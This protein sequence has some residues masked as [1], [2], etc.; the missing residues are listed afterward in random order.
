[1]NMTHPGLPIAWITTVVLVMLIITV[2]SLAKPAPG[3]QSGRTFNLSQIPLVGPLVNWL[4]TS[5]QLLL[6]LKLLMVLIFLTVIVAGLFG[7]P[8]PERNF[9]TLITWNFWWAGLVF[10]IFFFGTAWCAV[11]PWDALA[12]WLVRRR[13]SKRAEPNNSLNWSLPRYL[14]NLWPALIL[15]VGLTW[16]E[17]GVGITTS[18]QGTALVAL[19]MVVMA[20]VSLALFK[21]KAFCRHICPVGRTVGAYSQLAVVEL[22]PADITICAGCTT[23]DCYH[24]NQLVE[25]CP[26]FLMMGKLKQNSYCT[27]CGN[28][29]QSCPDDNVSWRLRAPSSEAAQGARPHW[30]EAWFMI[31][32]LALTAFHGLTMMPFWEGWM[33][34]LGRTLG[35]SVQLLWSFTVGLLL[36]VVAV[37]G[38]YALLISATRRL[39]RTPLDFKRSFSAL[40]FVALPLAFTYHLAHNLNHLVRESGNWL[41]VMINPLGINTL[42]LSMAEKHLRLQPIWPSA[43][44]LNALQAGLMIIGFLIALKIIRHRTPTLLSSG[45]P[46]TT[47]HHLPM[48]GFATIIT[49]SHLWMLAQPMTMRM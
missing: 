34:S 25:P 8:I 36:C 37:A 46:L 41:A 24:G 30:D 19:L 9:A 1:M 22:R 39:T 28:C 20:T 48:I 32:L 43:D 44:Y 49:G 2:W 40:A 42:P 27:A 31:G 12:Q 16:L 7:T 6:A 33:S 11:C 35:D 13:L 17:L 29:T 26:T 4:T 10:S 14:Q 38:F 18:P 23:L 45:Q 5:P 47:L 15:L 21:R 3:G